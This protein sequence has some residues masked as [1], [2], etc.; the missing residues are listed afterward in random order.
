MHNDFANWYQSTNIDNNSEKLELR[1]K[2]I[3]QVSDKLNYVQIP[4]LVKIAFCRGDDE[5]AES[6]FKEEFKKHD[7][8]FL[9]NEN[10]HEIAVLA[11]SVL[12]FEMSAEYDD[13][14]LI[15][16]SILTTYF[17]EERK[18]EAK[19]DLIGIA[20]NTITKKSHSA[21]TRPAYKD[22]TF[23]NITQQNIIDKISELDQQP[24]WDKTREIM[25]YMT[26]QILSH[27]NKNRTALQNHIEPVWDY[28]T[29][30]DE[31]LEMAWWLVNKWC[32]LAE[33][34]FNKVPPDMRA[35]LFG[36]EI[37]DMLHVYIEPPSLVGM[38][39]NTGVG[40]NK[41]TVPEAV[42]ACGTE[43]LSKFQN[44]TDACTTL[45]PIHYAISRAI[46]TECEE[47][48]I[49]AWHNVCG[50]SETKKFSAID[51][52]TQL[53]RECV[54]LMLLADGGE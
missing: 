20:N 44:L 26:E 14:D 46:E 15:A 31:E 48:W 28:I 16:T 12:A 13:A 52:A 29:V 3:K 35:L 25:Q 32:Q 8:G 30:Q 43:N 6:R 47:S 33:K 11:S 36:K 7:P 4:N 10:D 41:L 53:H 22:I 2:G 27:T 34:P 9:M 38:L 23:P 50:I 21:R 5:E 1:W 17:Y 49:P 40:K 54:V 37:A 42:N 39:S 51:I 18:P 24:D 45:T 19:F